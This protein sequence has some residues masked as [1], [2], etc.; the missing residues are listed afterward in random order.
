MIKSVAFFVMMISAAVFLS[1]CFDA[2]GAA[3]GSAKG[4]GDS[5]LQQTL[6][7]PAPAGTLALEVE[8]LADGLAYPWAMAF[9]PDG[10][11][12]VTEREGRVRLIRE[13]R[14]DPLP[15]VGVPEILVAGQAGLFDILLHPAFSTN[16]LVYLTYAHGVKRKNVLRV[17]RA[18]FEGG[19]F[20][21]WEVLHDARPVKNTTHHFG[22]RMAWGGDGKLYVTVGEGS[23]YKEKAQD[24]TT[25]LGAVLRLNG[26][27]SVP[28][29]NPVF[30]DGSQPA[31][32]TKGHRNSQGLTYDRMRAILWASEHGPRGGDEINIIRRGENYGWPLATYGTNYNGTKITPFTEYEGTM[33]P[34]KYWTPSIAPSGLAVYGGDLFEGW[35][36]DLLAG[37]MAGAALH[38][39]IM[40][41]NTPVGEERYL[42][43]RA[44]RVRDVRVGPEGAIYVTTEIKNDPTSGK[45]LRLTPQD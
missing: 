4:G 6:A 5:Q 31:L 40:E 12:L 13:G 33:Q 27:G 37:A 41:G 11:L 7:D 28:A 14:L 16:Q 30:G 43:E 36:G 2:D 26:D 1:G 29:D 35:S 39:I 19:A 18:R 24:M 32:Y 42:L 15:V 8:T 10:A 23:R 44:A 34:V 21:D 45:V 22:G 9:L 3:E 20:H 38:R 25:S 17:A